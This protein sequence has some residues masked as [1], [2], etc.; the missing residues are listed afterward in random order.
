MHFTP[1]QKKE[2]EEEKKN[3]CTINT[4]FFSHLIRHIYEHRFPWGCLG[5]HP[6]WDYQVIPQAHDTR[7]FRKPD[8]AIV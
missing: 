5:S 7:P 6:L 1:A 2:E 8:Q 3:H 4:Y